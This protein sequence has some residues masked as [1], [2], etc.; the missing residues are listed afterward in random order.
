MG[1]LASLFKAKLP[2]EFVKRLR[3]LP[4][5]ARAPQSSQQPP[6]V[7]WGPQKVRGFHEAAEF[8][9]RD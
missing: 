3:A 5:A 1:R 7:L 2:P 4:A 6:G 8:V 9:C